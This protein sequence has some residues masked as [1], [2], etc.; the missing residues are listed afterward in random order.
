MSGGARVLS[1]EGSA[2]ISGHDDVTNE[3]TAGALY[4]L[5]AG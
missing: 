5:A 1:V 2:A 4:S 3:A